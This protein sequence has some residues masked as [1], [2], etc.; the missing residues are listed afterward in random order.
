MNDLA[1]E[2]QPSHKRRVEMVWE[3]MEDR[4]IGYGVQ[5]PIEEIEKLVMLRRDTFKFA[6][7]MIDISN[8]LVQRGFVLSCSETNQKSY[9]IVPQA[10]NAKALERWRRE[11]ISSA[12]RG[13][14]LAG[15][16][17]RDGLSFED[18]RRLERNAELAACDLILLRNARQAMAL[19]KTSPMKSRL[20]E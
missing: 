16:T 12:K 13:V 9:R 1:G 18:I 4:G 17:P 20:R 7:V 11:R 19:L 14:V 15:A 2:N 6:R 3:W 8:E 10:D 5:F